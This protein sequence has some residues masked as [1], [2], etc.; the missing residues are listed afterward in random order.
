VSNHRF[1]GPFRQ[2]LLKLYSQCPRKFKLLNV[3]GIEVEE[4]KSVPLIIGANVHRLIHSFHKREPIDWRRGE[5]PYP[6]WEEVMELVNAY[7]NNNRGLEVI[8]S[9]ASFEFNINSYTIEGTIDLIY[10]NEHG[11]VVLRDIKTDST[12]PSPGFLARD[13]QFSVYYLGAIRGLG[14]KPDVLEWYH[15][16]NLVP[17]KRATTKNGVKFNAGDI[18]GNPSF[19]VS[20]T[21]EDIPNIE[22][23]IRY[24]IQGIRFRI[25]PMRPLKI[26]HI[27]PCNLCE[28]INYCN[29]HGET[30]AQTVE[31]GDLQGFEQY[32]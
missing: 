10:R 15:I 17:Y 22:R 13:I 5:I 7:T 30:I 24:I 27:C 18:R 26:G 31:A 9:E 28:A 29:P 20:R 25:F 32:F 1:S 11:Q 6:V 12:E 19:P 23:E 2:S 14:I 3:D 4:A 21:L 16:R 8:H